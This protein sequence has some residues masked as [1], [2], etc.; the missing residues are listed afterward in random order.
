M[1]RLSVVALAAV[2]LVLPVCA[3]Q[4]SA[5][6]GSFSAHSSPAFRGGLPQLRIPSKALP[7]TQVAVLLVPLLVSSAALLVTSSHAPTT[8]M[9]LAAIADLIKRVMATEYRTSGPDG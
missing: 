9:V 7:A 3:A 5:A 1:K 4:R 6:H 8:I 2:G